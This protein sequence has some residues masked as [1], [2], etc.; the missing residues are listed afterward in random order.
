MVSTARHRAANRGYWG[1]KFG[2][3]LQGGIQYSQ[4]NL[5][6]AMDYTV[7]FSSV[8]FGDTPPL[9]TV[10][11]GIA[12]RLATGGVPNGNYQEVF[13]HIREKIYMRLQ[14]AVVRGKLKV[15]DQ[16]GDDPEP[17]IR[18]FNEYP[19]IFTLYVKKKH[20]IAWGALD[21][22][23]FTFQDTDLE[24]T[25]VKKDLSVALESPATKAPTDLNNAVEPGCDGTARRNWRHLVQEEAWEHWLR[26]RAS[27]CNPSVFS[28]CDD[29]AK[30]CQ[31]NNIKGAKGQNPAAGTIRNTVLGAGHWTPP[32]HSV[33]EAK[34]LVAQIAQTAQI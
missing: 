28:I 16:F 2:Y 6:T 11:D 15:C 19:D 25:L 27:G 12:H 23:T 30:W 29:M 18:L 1:D 13:E 24:S 33:E 34:R 3:H 4:N 10:A 14:K 31:I 32:Q 17:M 26:L 7:K 21:G 5:E 9:P 22:D 20:L 8:K